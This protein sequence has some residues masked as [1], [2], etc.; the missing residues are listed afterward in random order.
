MFGVG[1][2]PD[3]P[4]Y[5]IVL[6]DG[7]SN[8]EQT[9][10]AGAKLANITVVAV[11]VGPDTLSRELEIIATAPDRVFLASAFSQLNSLVPK[12]VKNVCEDIT[13]VDPNLPPVDGQWSLWELWSSCS[14]TCGVGQQI[15]TRSCL[16]RA[17]GGMDCPGE[18]KYLARRRSSKDPLALHYS[19]CD[20]VLSQ[21]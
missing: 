7:G 13:P 6:T 3:A 8:L 10:K 4:D 17:N 14:E 1:D 12:V 18:S 21:F 20:V 11:G 2:R 15:R 5:L 9:Q 19:E 16:G